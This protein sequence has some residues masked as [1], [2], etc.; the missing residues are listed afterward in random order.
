MCPGFVLVWAWVTI[1]GVM[2]PQ[3]YGSWCAGVRGGRVGKCSRPMAGWHCIG[4]GVR[5]LSFGGRT[6][7]KGCGP[8]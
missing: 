6:V 2:S 4:V 1:V 7:E 3:G 8:L 5:S